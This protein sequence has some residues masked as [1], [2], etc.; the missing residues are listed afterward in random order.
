MEVITAEIQETKAIGLREKLAAYLELTK[1]RIALMLVLTSA[2]GFYLG[3]AKGLR[4]DAFHQC[5]DR[6]RAAR[7]RSGDA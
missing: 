4:H 5:D 7:L 1:P 2:A 3:A 6:H